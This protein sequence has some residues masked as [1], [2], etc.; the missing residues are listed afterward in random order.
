MQVL[1]CFVLNLFSRICPS[2]V[3]VHGK[4]DSGEQGAEGPRCCQG[5]ADRPGVVQAG[6]PDLPCAGRN[7]LH[8]IVILRGTRGCAHRS[9]PRA[10]LGK[11]GWPYL[12]TS[13]ENSAF[14]SL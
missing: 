7:V 4:E 2:V 12:P 10:F 3:K 1:V 9:F 5:V 8:K 14:D 6:A 11:Q 13:W